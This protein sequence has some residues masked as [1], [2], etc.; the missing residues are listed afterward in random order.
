MHIVYEVFKTDRK[1]FWRF[2][3]KDRQECI[4]WIVRHEK[5]PSIRHGLSKLVIK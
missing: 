4:K 3:S 1:R 5:E 2:E